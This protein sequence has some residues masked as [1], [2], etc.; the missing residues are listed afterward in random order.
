M[1]ECF[2]FQYVLFNRTLHHPSYII[3][4]WNLYAKEN[5]MWSC[6][7]NHHITEKDHSLVKALEGPVTDWEIDCVQLLRASL[8]FS[9]WKIWAT[10]RCKSFLFSGRQTDSTAGITLSDICGSVY[11]IL[12]NALWHISSRGSHFHSEYVLGL[13]YVTFSDSCQFYMSSNG[14]P[15]V[16]VRGGASVRNWY[17]SSFCLTESQNNCHPTSLPLLRVH[18]LYVLYTVQYRCA[19]GSEDCKRAKM[20]YMWETLFELHLVFCSLPNYCTLNLNLVSAPC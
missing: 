14:G 8:H 20:F 18:A 12:H 7:W 6:S 11:H 16:G 4:R 3:I 17:S 5:N 13:D 10:C 15:S 19:C 2:I 9:K 1:N